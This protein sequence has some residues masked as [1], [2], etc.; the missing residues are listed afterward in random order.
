MEDEAR[1]R[2]SM[3]NPLQQVTAR[4]ALVL[5]FAALLCSP[6]PGLAG[7]IGYLGS[8]QS[9]AVLGYAGVTNAHSDPNPQTQIYGNV[10]VTP[11]ALTYIT[12]F[13]PGTVTG[14]TLLGPG[15][16]SPSVA[17]Q[18]LADIDAAAIALSLLGVT[19]TY[20]TNLGGQTVV[21]GVYDLSSFATTLT[22]TVI[23]DAQNSSNALFVFILPST[24]TTASN[25]V[26]SVINGTPGTQVYW[27]LGSSAELGSGSTFE[28]NILAYARIALDPTAKIEC[29]RAFSETASVTLIDNNISGNCTAQNFGSTQ[30][31]FGSLG[32]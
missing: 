30:S 10:G 9:F 25:S 2:N 29:G 21:P 3:R 32:F 23:L 27:V 14:G 5:A 7:T 6:S 22:G 4:A 11:A 24:L 13:P 17:D 19:G 8:A 16:T 31:D 28:G 15:P 26:V 1:R 12:G 18:A 20:S